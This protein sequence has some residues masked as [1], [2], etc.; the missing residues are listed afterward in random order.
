[1]SIKISRP[2]V[3][4]IFFCHCINIGVAQNFIKKNFKS[5][6]FEINVSPLYDNNI[7]KYSSIYIEKFKTGYDAGRYHISTIDDLMLYTSVNSRFV[8]RF[9]KQKDTRF[10]FDFSRRTYLNNS[11]KSWNYF[12]F[13]IEQE[14]SN[15]IKVSFNY[16]YIPEYYI[17]HYRDN[18]WVDIYGYTE[19]T[20]KPQSFSKES[21]IF[22]VQHSLTHHFDFKLDLGYSRYFYNT[23]FTEYD[24]VNYFT[25]VKSYYTFRKLIKTALGIRFEYSDSNRKIEKQIVQNRYPNPSNIEGGIEL[26]F[27]INIPEIH[28]KVNGLQLRTQFQKRIY[29]SESYYKDDP[30]HS[31]RV[32]DEIEIYTAYWMKIFK[33]FKISLFN[34]YASRS[35]LNS[36]DANTEYLTNEKSYKQNI[37][38]IEFSYFLKYH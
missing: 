6:L 17:R 27:N 32:D 25:R 15:R 4:G 7:L 8:F 20:F 14:L 33:N 19:E 16:S 24:C 23:H 30:L 1:M 3:M 9:I 5:V 35:L 28:G 13:G 34:Q 21:Y 36:I 31:G 11:I 22:S 37:A 10:D 12:N 26:D 38:G 2:L 18:D 29:T